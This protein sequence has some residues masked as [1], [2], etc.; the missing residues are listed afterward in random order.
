MVCGIFKYIMLS[1]GLSFGNSYL[2]PTD[3]PLSLGTTPGKFIKLTPW[4]NPENQ[5]MNDPCN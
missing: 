1:L 2:H 5:P 4:E 3:S